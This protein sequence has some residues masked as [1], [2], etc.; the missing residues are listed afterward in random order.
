MIGYHH[1]EIELEDIYFLTGLSK[2]G[3][4]ISLFGARPGGQSASSL[5]HEFFNEEVDPKDKRIDIK[6]II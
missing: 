3:E 6:T 5:K 2:R 1:L 4:P